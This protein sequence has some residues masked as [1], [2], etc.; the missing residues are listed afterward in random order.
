M[1][2]RLNTTLKKKLVR[3]HFITISSHP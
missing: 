2:S 3:E 1:T